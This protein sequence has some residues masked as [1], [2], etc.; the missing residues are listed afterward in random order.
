MLDQRLLRQEHH[1]MDIYSA[2]KEG[3]EQGIERGIVQEKRQL[4]GTMLSKGLAPELVCEIAG[5]SERE[6]DR[7]LSDDLSH[8]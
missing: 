4:V 8:G 7:L 5:I 3:I 6:L 1:D 2:R